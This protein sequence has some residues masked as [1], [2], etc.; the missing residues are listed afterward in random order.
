MPGLPELLII[1]MFL[2][3]LVLIVLVIR[4]IIGTLYASK[5]VVWI[6]CSI[7]VALVV[8]QVIYKAMEYWLNKP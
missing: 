1:S 6:L 3:M 8:L 2:L 7:A 4:I 5:K